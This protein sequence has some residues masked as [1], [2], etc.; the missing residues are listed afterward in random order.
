MEAIDYIGRNKAPG[1]DGLKDI[2]LKRA[3]LRDQP[4]VC[5]LAAH[6]SKWL[7]RNKIPTYVKTAAITVLSKT[8]SH[9]PPLGKGRPIAV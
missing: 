9:S 3:V 1:L 6:F 2:Y 5:K 8:D 4:L 7:T